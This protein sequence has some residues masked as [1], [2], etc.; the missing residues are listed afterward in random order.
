MDADKL[1]GIESK[2]RVIA[3][4][5]DD[6]RIDDAA[7]EDSGF[8]YEMFEEILE[9]ADQIRIIAQPIKVINGNSSK[10]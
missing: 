5:L 2:L 10:S 7:E 6:Y 1:F 9:Q 8:L 3:N 4:K